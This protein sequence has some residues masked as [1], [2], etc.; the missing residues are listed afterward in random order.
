MNLIRF[1]KSFIHKYIEIHRRKQ[2][3]NITDTSIIPSNVRVY[4][5]KNLIM[6]EDTL[7]GEN[8]VIMNPRAPFVMKKFSFTAREILVLD[9]NHMSIVGIPM[10]KVTDRVKD[11]HPDGGHYNA[12]VVVEEDVWIGARVILLSGVTVG[13]GSIVAAGAVVTK[14]IPPYCIA[15][16]VPA[17]V[18][19]P[20]WSIE[21]IRS[22]EIALYSKE[23]RINVDD[24]SKKLESYYNGVKC[25]H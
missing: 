1:I 8:S 3:T 24:L 11:A 20:K 10:I 7:I 23:E 22:H 14:D 13:R 12:P 6:E 18:I 2:Y 9:G 16:G 19:R 21:E 5:K 17:K 15:G 4:N 25:Q